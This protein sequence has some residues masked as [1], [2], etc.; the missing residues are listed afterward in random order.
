MKYMVGIIVLFL[1]VA[2]PLIEFGQKRA[3][4]WQDIMNDIAVRADTPPIT[5]V[6]YYFKG[7]NFTLGETAIGHSTFGGIE[8]E[9]TFCRNK[10][11]EMHAIFV[12][13][14]EHVISSEPSKTK[15]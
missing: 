4:F 3:A 1:T 10:G 15:S 12:T 9:I 11:G 13:T 7:C 14:E 5:D 8:T 6:K 2:T